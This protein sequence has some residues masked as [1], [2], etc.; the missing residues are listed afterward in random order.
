MLGNGLLVLFSVAVALA[1]CEA[2]LRHFHPR[3]VLAAAAPRL[4]WA[5]TQRYHFNPD[6][7][8]EHLV[9][10]NNLGGRQSR[11]FPAGSLENG[12]NIA[13][14]GD[15]QTENVH[16]SAQYSYSE[17]LDFLLN[18]MAATPGEQVDRMLVDGVDDDDS[19]F[20]VL[21][22][23]L[24]GYGTGRSYLRWRSLP[25]RRELDHVFYMVV[26]NDLADLH[27][28]LRSGDVR[29]SEAGEV[30]GGSP[31]K[32]AWK[33]LLARLHMT[34]LVADVV[35][36]L[37]A[38]RSDTLEPKRLRRRATTTLAMKTM[39]VFRELVRRWKREV[40][41]EDGTFHMV[42]V[43]GPSSEWFRALRD[44]AELRAEIGLFD[45]IEC[46]DE[47]VPGSPGSPGSFNYRHWS[48][49]HG[50]HWNARANMAAASCLYRY[51]E[52][53]LGLP[54]R[55]DKDL[56]HARH[57]Y[58]QAFLDSPVWQGERY[59]PDAA[60]ARPGRA[61]THQE[62]EAVVAKYLALELTPPTEAVAC[63]WGVGVVASNSPERRAWSLE[64]NYRHQVAT[65][66]FGNCGHEW[67][68]AVRA[69]R[70]AEALATT[71]GWSVYANPRQRLL[72]YVKSP[73]PANW[74]PAGR[75]FLHAVPFTPEK[76]PLPAGP[77]PPPRFVNLDKGPFSPL[78]RNENECVFSVQLPDYP[79]STGK[80][81]RF[82]VAGEGADTVY[83]NLWSVAF[84]FPLVRSVWDVYAG[85]GRSLDYVKEACEGADT[86][87]RFFLHVFPLR[88]ADLRGLPAAGGGRRYANLD[89]ASR[90]G[91]DDGGACR[92]SAALPDFPIDFVRTGQFRDGVVFTERLWSARIDFAEVERLRSQNEVGL[93]APL[94]K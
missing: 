29:V 60:W 37:A 26:D 85:A 41:A 67:L 34:Y 38:S 44:D 77:L 56:A 32:P 73:C 49:R 40:E 80:T 66:L 72:V 1:V 57:A 86:A 27:N 21:N 24:W 36:R 87:E 92:I 18:N 47:A 12:V 28:S 70:E 51:L 74:R 2:A 31:S 90:N 69:A 22:F 64:R 11:D 54:K 84:R 10:H 63:E 30:F 58:Y 81:G 48:F 23:G 43:P 83:N 17:L 62:G 33:R 6:T 68:G 20:N 19:S 46:F 89:F 59:V 7:R 52:S 79:L 91:R 55:S 42:L 71:A 8:T 25:V 45:L 3:Y 16:L 82:T 35:R 4:A 61:T 65:A 75:F 76:L 14:F 15:S 50:G 13:F 93:G 88:P 5:N 53:E 94:P 78:R 9:I 39:P